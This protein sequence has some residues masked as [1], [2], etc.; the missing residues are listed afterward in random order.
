MAEIHF[1]RLAAK[2]YRQARQWYAQ[3]SRKALRRF[4]SAV[5]AALSQIAANPTSWPMYESRHRWKKAARF[6][7]LLIYRRPDDDIVVVAV[8]HTSRRPGYWKRRTI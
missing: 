8:A 4:V 1:H 5:D 7:Y 2:E 6:P 3:R